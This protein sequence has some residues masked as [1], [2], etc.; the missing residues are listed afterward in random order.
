MPCP[1]S[2][3]LP[4]IKISSDSSSFIVLSVNENIDYWSGML[5][6]DINRHSIIVMKLMNDKIEAIF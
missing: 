4:V 6:F 2:G 1:D 3:S 5:N